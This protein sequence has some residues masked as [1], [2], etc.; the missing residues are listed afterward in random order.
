MARSVT[1]EFVAALDAVTGRWKLIVARAYTACAV[2]AS[3]STKSLGTAS[4]EGPS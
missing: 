4:R 3:A 1:I 2:P